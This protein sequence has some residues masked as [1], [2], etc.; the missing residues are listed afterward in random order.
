MKTRL[1]IL[2]L[3]MLA[4]CGEGGTADEGHAAAKG[5]L[6]PCA[7]EGA[8]SLTADCRMERLPGPEGTTLTIRHRSGSFRRLLVTGDGLGVVAADGADPATVSVVDE[9]RIEVSVAGDRYQLPASLK[10]AR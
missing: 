4:A 3:P 6:I 2:L 9:K 1:S 8:D 10:A 5:E 7:V